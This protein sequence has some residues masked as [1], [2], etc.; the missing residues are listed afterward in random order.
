MYLFYLHSN[1]LVNISDKNHQY[2]VLFT[3]EV[4]VP[5]DESRLESFTNEQA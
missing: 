5:V 1:M 3:R 4:Y 2:F